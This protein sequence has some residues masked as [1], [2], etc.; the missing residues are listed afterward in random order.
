MQSLS[1]R[2]ILF[3]VLAPALVVGL[4]L[5]LPKTHG[6]IPAATAPPAAEAFPDHVLY[7]EPDDFATYTHPVH[8]FSF[9]YPQDYVLLTVV[10]GEGE[11]VRAVRPLFVA[12]IEVTSVGAG[13]SIV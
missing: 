4:A 8:G 9:L 12:G 6:S 3:V 7:L 1:R 2:Y 10:T 13:D 5:G 11:T